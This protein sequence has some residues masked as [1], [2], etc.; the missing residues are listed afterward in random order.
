LPQRFRQLFPG[1][2]TEGT[3]LNDPD[4]Y[5]RDPKRFA[6]LTTAIAEKRAA[7]E[8]AEHR[9]LEVAEMAEQ[10]ARGASVT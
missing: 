10:L 7:K 9:W 8:A 6:A 5:S 3:E 2:R 1:E 4:L